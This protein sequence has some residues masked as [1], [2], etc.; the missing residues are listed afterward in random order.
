LNKK[1]EVEAFG[2]QE[3]EG[4]DFGGF[5]PFIGQPLLFFILFFCYILFETPDFFL[6]VVHQP[7][8]S[9]QPP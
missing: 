2:D 9:S 5:W 8:P 3:P 7:N 1:I 6:N 4:E